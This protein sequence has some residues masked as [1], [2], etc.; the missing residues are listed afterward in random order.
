MCTG[1][2]P[3]GEVRD[4]KFPDRVLKREPDMSKI[5]YPTTRKMIELMLEKDKKKRMKL[6]DLFP[7]LV[8]IVKELQEELD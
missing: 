7:Q 8:D 3:F 1:S 4:R 2:H 5:P 6:E